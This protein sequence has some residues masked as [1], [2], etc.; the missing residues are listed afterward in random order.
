M[1]ASCGIAYQMCSTG[2]QSDSSELLEALLHTVFASLTQP[3]AS[4]YA[5]RFFDSKAK[6]SLKQLSYVHAQAPVRCD[7]AS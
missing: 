4:F 5:R 1:L 3:A 7:K 6:D 2:S